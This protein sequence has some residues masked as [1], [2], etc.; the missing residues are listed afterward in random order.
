MCRDLK[1]MVYCFISQAK[2]DQSTF[3]QNLVYYKQ[4]LN[5]RNDLKVD[6]QAYESQ[7]TSVQ[8]N[9]YEIVI[10]RRLFSYQP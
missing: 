9:N 6:S 7:Q 4:S 2:K 10:C 1:R 5:R 3:A 8:V